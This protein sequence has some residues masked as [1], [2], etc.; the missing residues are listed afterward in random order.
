MLVKT[1]EDYDRLKGL[2]FEP[3]IDSRF[4]MAI[5]LRRKIQAL[6][7]GPASPENDAI[8]YR[9]V[10]DHKPH[11]CEETGQPIPFYSAVNISHIISR[12][13]N[14]ELRY[15]PRNVNL[16]IYQVHNLWETGELSLKK[17][18][19]IWPWNCFIIDLLTCEYQIKN[20]E[21]FSI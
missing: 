5:N 1:A 6:Y 2:G 11:Y 21:T 14:T 17:G 16:V 19:N 18:L 7:F 9:W 20:Y 13:A 4:N 10:Y 8:F 15:D 3:L 12:G